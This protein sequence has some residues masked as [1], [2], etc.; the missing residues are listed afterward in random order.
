MKKVVEQHTKAI[1]L[2]T[3]KKLKQAIDI[4]NIMAGESSDPAIR[5]ELG[6]ITLTY[7]NMLKYTIEGVEDPEREKIYTKI[8]HDLLRLADIVKQDI[9]SQQSDWHT[10]RIKQNE[11]RAQKI[12]G[13]HPVITASDLLFSADLDALP[14]IDQGSAPIHGT[15]ESKKRN[16]LITKVFNRLW[17]TDYYSEADEYLASIITGS[18]KFNWHEVALFLSSITLSCLR[19]FQV[20]KIGTIISLSTHNN[21][22]I[23]GRAMAGLVLILHYHD[24]RVKLYPEICRVLSECGEDEAFRERCRMIVLQVLRSRETE[25]LGRKL[26]EEILPKVAKLKP[27]IEEKLDLDNILPSDMGNEENPDWSE[28]FE[29]SEE[30]YRTFEELSKLQMEGADVYMQAFSNLKHFDFFRQLS[31]WLLPFHPDHETVDE[32]FRDEILG[33][34]TNELAEALYRT[35]FICNSDKYSLLLNLKHLPSQQKSMML[36]VFRMELEGLAQY[37]ETAPAGD[38][39]R[40][41]RIVITQYLQD[42]YRFFKLS[43]YRNEFEDIF[44]GRLEIYNSFF[45]KKHFSTPEADLNMADYLFR[46]EFYD[47]AYDIYRERAESDP[48]NALIYEKMG[49]CYQQSG[50]WQEA[51]KWYRRAEMVERKVWTVKKIG[52]SLRKIGRHEEALDYYLQAGDIESENNHTTLMTAHCYLKLQEYEKALKYYFRI[53]YSNPGN[54]RIL[55]PIGWCYFAMGKYDD[56]RRYYQRIESSK[57]SGHDL[58]NIGHI[59]FCTGNKAEAAEMYRRAITV[60]GISRKDFVNIMKHDEDILM[61]NGVTDTDIIM[62]TDYVLFFV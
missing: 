39:N 1:S 35:P 47:E 18:K 26:T 53:E 40:K 6:S 5:D 50:N 13:K 29:G 55:R 52:L 23:S 19:V 28:M 56:S 14:D 2:I 22:E 58:I 37:E 54:D 41:F 27:R 51:L 11:E 60:A 24:K 10:Y 45:Y 7:S 12:S 36:K 32:I 57:V 9:L 33:E 44:S 48:S 16:E 34:G 17:L 4:L 43:P 15:I 21:A 62:V 30:I 38:P 20:K 31:N 61:D 3:S 25:K 49:Y 46:K 59:A 8:L 42:L